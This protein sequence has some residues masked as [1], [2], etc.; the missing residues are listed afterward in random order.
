MELTCQPMAV[1]RKD[2][3]LSV[4]PRIVGARGLKPAFFATFVCQN[5]FELSGFG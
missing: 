3:E 4:F 2:L 1:G 5:D